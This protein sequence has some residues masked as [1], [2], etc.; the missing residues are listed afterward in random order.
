MQYRRIK[1]PGACVFL[2][3]V[4]HQRQPLLTTDSNINRL[5]TAF[6]RELKTHP[7]QLDAIV[8]LP[9]H[10]HTLWT[11]PSGDYDYQNRV[12]RI[13]RYFSIGCKGSKTSQSSAR[14]KK[15]YKPVW[16]QRYW[17]HT[18]RDQKDF[19]HHMDYIHYNPVKHGQVDHPSE[20]PFS[21]FHRYIDS[22]LYNADWG[23]SEPVSTAGIDLE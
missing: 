23:T 2:T 14:T 4:T 21:S 1:N 13:K 8:I 12:S 18:I 7:F 19:S 3:L 22:G 6:R 10:L 11:L 15:R 20:W 9:D 16:Q 17:E 5:R